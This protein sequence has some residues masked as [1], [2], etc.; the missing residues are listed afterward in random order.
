[1]NEVDPVRELMISIEIYEFAF[2]PSYSNEL[3]FNTLK[4]NLDLIPLLV[5][6]HPDWITRHPNYFGRSMGSGIYRM[7]SFLAPERP[8][9]VTDGEYSRGR[10]GLMEAWKL[11][12]SLACVSGICEIYSRTVK[13]AEALS[14]EL[15]TRVRAQIQESLQACANCFAIQQTNDDRFEV[16]K[17]IKEVMED[18]LSQVNAELEQMAARSVEDQ[19]CANDTMEAMEDTLSQVTAELE[20]M[21]ARSVEDQGCANDTMSLSQVNA[22]LEQ[23]DAIS[24]EDQDC[25]NDTTSFWQILVSW[26]WSLF[27]A[28]ESQPEPDPDTTLEHTGQKIVEPVAEPVNDTKDEVYV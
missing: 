7:G 9:G 26:F 5:M 21:A 6:Q 28:S 2:H 25:S 12:A 20:Q 27:G 15:E 19:G 17:Q 18:T 10:S 1:M 23:M 11:R 13:E 4:Q 24:I 14:C 3:I 16:L 8:Y 22:E